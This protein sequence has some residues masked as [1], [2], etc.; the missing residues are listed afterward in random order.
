VEWRPGSRSEYHAKTGLFLAAEALRSRLPGRPSWEEICREWLLDPIGA[1]TMT[2]RIPEKRPLSLTPPP[3]KLPWEVTPEHFPH[4]GHPGGGIF[5][6]LDDMIRVLQ[7]HLNGGSWNGRQILNREHVE[8]MR[9]VQYRKEILETR[10]QERTPAFEPYGVGWRIKLNQQN[11][12][13]GLGNR[14]PE[15]T[16]GHAGI[17]T[18]MSVAIPQ[19]DLAIAFLCTRPVAIPADQ[20]RIRNHITD[21]IYEASN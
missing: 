7:F 17:G 20:E 15:G 12:G 1:S 11:D 2:F 18:V 4:L 19:K 6:R 21:L 10:A 9:R 3:E 16:F 14:T 5:G 13:F 8:E